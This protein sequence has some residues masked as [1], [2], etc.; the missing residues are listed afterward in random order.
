MVFSF[1]FLRNGVGR[2]ESH[3][4]LT[5]AMRMDYCKYELKGLNN[6]TEL[7]QKLWQCVDTTNTSSRSRYGRR[8]HSQ[9][10][11]GGDDISEQSSPAG[12][13]K[14]YRGY[15]VLDSKEWNE[16]RDA[17]VKLLKI[18]YERKLED[19]T[20]GEDIIRDIL[21]CDKETI[22]LFFHILKEN[23]D[24]KL[25]ICREIDEAGRIEIFNR[26]SF[27]RWYCDALYEPKKNKGEKPFFTYHQT[28]Y[29]FNTANDNPIAIWMLN[30]LIERP[31][32]LR[33][34]IVDKSGYK[35]RVVLNSSEWNGIRSAFVRLL[36]IDYKK[37]E[38][39]FK[40]EDIIKDILRYREET[41]ML[42]FH[43]LCANVDKELSICKQID[44]AERV[45]IYNRVILI[46]EYYLAVSGAEKAA[47]RKYFPMK[48]GKFIFRY[49][50]P[51]YQFDINA[52]NP[53]AVWIR[54]ALRA[55]YH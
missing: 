30:G 54:S 44:E 40:G 37:E 9:R 28:Q 7:F 29:Q 24:K 49:T 46:A 18:D 32:F 19:Q 26:V 16:I 33:K 50:P 2:P 23:V 38:N 41:I 1:S 47:K 45:E 42:F 52:Y 31:F 25:S 15:V 4:L 8:R 48:D 34:K 10:I 21:K 5:P 6:K 39:A 53:V 51:R 20:R 12:T 11:D 3:V 17:F 55:G 22:L 14:G 36:Q 35:G 43:I 27:I 13:P